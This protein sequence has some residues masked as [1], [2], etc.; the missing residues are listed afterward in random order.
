MPPDAQSKLA[1]RRTQAWPDLLSTLA[2]CAGMLWPAA[3]PAQPGIDYSAPSAWLCLPGRSDTCAA[4]LTSTVIPSANGELSKRS[5]APD[6]AAPID[7]F[8]VYPTVSRESTANADMAL[9]PEEQHA[10][11]EQFARFS[12]KCRTYAP[13]YRQTTIAAMNGE[14]SGADSEL[15]Y[16]D[17]LD[18]WRFYLAHHNQGR[19]FVL[20]GHSQGA[21]LLVRL[22]SEQIDGR[23]IQRQL[24]S[25]LLTGANIQVPTGRDEGGTFQHLPLC[26]KAAQ[27]GCVIAY[28]S[29]LATH[30]PGSDAIFGA[31]AGP[32]SSNAC[33]NPG[34]L[35]DEGGLDSELPTV[36][37]VATALGT[38]L[39][40][41]PGLISGTCTTIGDRTFLAVA[42]KT[43][44]I[45]AEQVNQPL[46]VLATRRPRWGLHALD[47]NLALGNLVEI[48]GRQGRAWMLNGHKDTGG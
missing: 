43:T 1:R 30:P 29:Y 35:T 24:V 27:T 20:I 47:I 8:Y 25:A 21:S 38:D 28:S 26:R 5:Y 6:P 13:L 16:R 11:Q 40:E 4:Q 9:G 33:V 32:A 15:A 34:A 10:A 36:G 18:A 19:G 7:C 42:I 41:N 46:T 37:E 22:A 17:V 48:V 12:A 31:A 45:G 44:G 2:C 39:V 23:K 3:A 14:A